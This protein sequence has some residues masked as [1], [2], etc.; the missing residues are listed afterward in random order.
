MA[1]E[2]WAWSGLL[3]PLGSKASRKG[4]GLRD[5]HH[6]QQRP[7]TLTAGICSDPCPQ[8]GSAPMAAPVSWLRYQWSGWPSGC[9]RRPQRAADSVRTSMVPCVYC[10]RQTARAK[11]R[12]AVGL[13][14][15]ASPGCGQWGTR[16]HLAGPA[17]MAG[18]GALSTW[19][20]R[21]L[22]VRSRMPVLLAR[23]SSG[24]RGTGVPVGC[25][26]LNL[27]AGHLH[28][29]SSAAVHSHAET[30]APVQP[31]LFPGEPGPM[32][33]RLGRALGSDSCPFPGDV[34]GPP[35]PHPFPQSLPLLAD[36]QTVSLFKCPLATGRRDVGGRA[37]PGP[38]T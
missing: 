22:V 17:P 30:A 9:R 38:D 16:D 25:H 35:P 36:Q 8:Q 2:D 15:A 1:K 29:R 20:S 12:E 3:L 33:S 6:G 19:L 4:R 31:G 37:G 10:L 32:C 26:S 28:A 5:A 27:P 7:H 23:E 21:W 14:P 24:T 34:P 11:S 13:W 18:V